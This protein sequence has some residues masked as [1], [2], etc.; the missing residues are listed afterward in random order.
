ML[1]QNEQAATTIHLSQVNAS[2]MQQLTENRKRTRWLS[3][4]PPVLRAL[5]VR[6]DQT[7]QHRH[8]K[9]KWAQVY[10]DRLCQA[11]A[12]AIVEYLG[13][14]APACYVLE[15]VEDEEEDEPGAVEDE[16]PGYAEISEA[17]KRA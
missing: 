14:P 4:M 13:K 9:A 5:D 10:P 6:Y 8:G 1:Q 3:K 7:H 11:V 16:C 2:Q 15:D 12:K 17:E